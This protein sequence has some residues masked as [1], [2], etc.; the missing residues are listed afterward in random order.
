ML[1]LSVLAVKRRKNIPLTVAIVALTV[2]P[3][4]EQRFRR[5]LAIAGGARRF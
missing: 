3:M 5:A 1:R 2:G 4:A